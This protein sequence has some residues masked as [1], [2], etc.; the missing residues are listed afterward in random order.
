MFKTIYLSIG[1][2]INR[3]LAELYIAKPSDPITFLSKWLLNENQSQEI[4][5]KVKKYHYDIT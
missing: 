3:G 2:I 1:G 4:T 5:N